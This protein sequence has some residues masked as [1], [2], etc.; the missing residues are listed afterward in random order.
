MAYAFVCLA[1]FLTSG[2]TF[3]SGFGLGTLLLPVF[4]LF[5]D[6]PTAVGM[7]AVVHFLNNLFKLFLLGRKADG[8]VVL[9][10]GGPAVLAAL[11]GA[12]A[13]DTLSGL[14]PLFLY[15]AFGRWWAVLPVKLALGLL[16][17]TF[18]FLEIMPRFE[19]LSFD[20]KHLP[21]GGL[22]SGFF[23]GLSGHQGALRSAFLIR[24]GL[25]KESFIAS[26]VVIACLVDV[27]RLGVY[28]ARLSSGALRDHSVLLACAVLS[29][30]LGAW[31]GNRLLEKVA[32]RMVRCSVVVLLLLVA[33][34]LASGLI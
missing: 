16:M 33:L 4:S 18:A 9:A 32:I 23:G 12:R 29:A 17:I 13:L 11:L 10:F 21:L 2:L 1:A 34:G 20:R 30:F 31:L 27:A 26:G 5:F 3:F 6:I 28:A 7:T 15:Q 24:C 25:S 22:L 8:A 14:D 19:R